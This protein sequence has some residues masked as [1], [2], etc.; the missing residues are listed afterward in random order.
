MSKYPW[1]SNYP[2]GVKHEINPDAYQS[3]PE[4]VDEMIGKYS[5]LVSFENMGKEITFSELGTRIDEFAS[6]IQN[7]TNLKKG[8]RIAIQMPNLTSISYFSLWCIKGGIS[9]GQ[10]QPAL[11]S[12]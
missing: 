7:H 10:Y 3:L 6:F 4:M 5:D 8:D 2:D 1:H 11:Y 9:C 12:K